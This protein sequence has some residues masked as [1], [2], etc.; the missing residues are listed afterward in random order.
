MLAHEVLLLAKSL[1][2][3]GRITHYKSSMNV[4]CAP[5]SFAHASAALL[6]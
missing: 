1:G 6:T 4:M 3:D 5:S 2:I